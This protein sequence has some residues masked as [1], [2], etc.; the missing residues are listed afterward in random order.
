MQFIYVLTNSTG[1]AQVECYSNA[2]FGCSGVS[3][4]F[5]ASGQDCC[6]DGFL[7]FNAGGDVC[8][9]CRGKVYKIHTWP[10]SN[11]NLTLKFSQLAMW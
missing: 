10:F 6:D 5:R 9:E 4:G 11:I 3:A 1:L 7:A 2:N 8:E